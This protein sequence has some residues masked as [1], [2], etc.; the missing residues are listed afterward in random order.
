MLL[1]LDSAG[2]TEVRRRCYTRYSDAMVKLSPSV[3]GSTYC[4][5]NN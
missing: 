5:S 2:K 4:S 3:K 1:E